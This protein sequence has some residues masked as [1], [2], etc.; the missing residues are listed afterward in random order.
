MTSIRQDYTKFKGKRRSGLSEKTLNVLKTYLINRRLQ[1]KIRSASILSIAYC[2]LRCTQARRLW[3]T[4]KPILSTI[5]IICLVLVIALT[6]A[7]Y[8]Y[9]EPIIK[10]MVEMLKTYNPKLFQDI[11]EADCNVKTCKGCCFL[12]G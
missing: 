2:S 10:R 5:I 7:L 8:T 3:K 9:H 6:A 11:L 1:Q 12:C 4:Y